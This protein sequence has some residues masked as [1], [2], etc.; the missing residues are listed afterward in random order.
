MQFGPAADWV[1][2]THIM[3]G[4]LLKSTSLNVTLLQNYPHETGSEFDLI[5]GHP[6]LN[7]VDT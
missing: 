6:G 3:E 2:P 7:H 1:S 4:D 5:F